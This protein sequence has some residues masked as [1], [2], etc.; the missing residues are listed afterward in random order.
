MHKQSKLL[1]FTDL[2][3][4]LI[5]YHTYSK[6]AALP[7]LEKISEFKIPLIIVSSKTRAEIEPMLDLPAM[8]KIFIAENG[9]A[10]FFHK[11]LGLN[12]GEDAP[13]FND[14]SAIILGER[15]ENILKGIH[16]AR[17][18]SG[19]QLQ[20]FSE[21]SVSEI[22]KVTGLDMQSATL[23]KTREFSEPFLFDGDSVDIVCFINALKENGITCVQGGRFLHALGRC[24]KG[25]A[26]RKVLDVYKNNYP[27]ISWKTI[28]LGDSEN[29]I[30]L[31]KIADIAVTIKRHDSTY[32]NYIPNRKQR[33]I[34]PRD[35]G[36]AGWNEA[37]GHILKEDMPSR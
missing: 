2:D 10:V 12:L 17:K 33:V 1:I 20:G 22:S 4:T 13:V 25:Q 23:A 6:K 29:D 19:I 18:Q 9:S 11:D 32:M 15:Y 16:Q 34:R 5:D 36:P 7:S 24:D 27:D 14:Y 8:A 35:I 21:M 3:G 37:V 26:A 30:E 28:A 31:L